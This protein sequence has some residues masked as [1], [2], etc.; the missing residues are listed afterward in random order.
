MGLGTL[1][2]PAQGHLILGALCSIILLQ[3]TK[4]MTS[5]DLNK[6]LSYWVYNDP[7]YGDDITNLDYPALI[8]I[9]Q[10]LVERM[11]Q[12]EQRLDKQEEYQQE[13]ND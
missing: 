1:E 10:D 5:R 9:L 2:E 8:L 13:Q 3:T 4:L 12:L 6:E 7:E 11:E